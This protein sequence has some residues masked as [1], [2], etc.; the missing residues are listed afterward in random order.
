MA[1]YNLQLIKTL[2]DGTQIVL[3]DRK[4]LDGWDASGI[5]RVLAKEVH[6]ARK[7]QPFPGEV[8]LDAA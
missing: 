4:K 5:L 3:A 8:T 1:T 6:E 2:E 7:W